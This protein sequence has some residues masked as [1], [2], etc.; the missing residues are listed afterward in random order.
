[1]SK[2]QDAWATSRSSQGFGCRHAWLSST[3]PDYGSDMLGQGIARFSS[4]FAHVAQFA[5]NFSD[6]VFHFCIIELN[7]TQFTH[8]QI[9]RNPLL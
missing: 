4:P 3:L 1:M 9:C 2:E 7:S 6:I 8:N 5:N